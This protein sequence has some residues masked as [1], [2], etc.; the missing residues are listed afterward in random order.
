MRLGSGNEAIVFGPFTRHDLL[1]MGI[2]LPVA[3]TDHKYILKVFKDRFEKLPPIKAPRGSIIFPIE[4]LTWDGVR[5]GTYLRWKDAR[6]NKS[7]IIEVQEYGG[8]DMYDFL[9]DRYTYFTSTDFGQVWKSVIAIF[10]DVYPLIG[11]ENRL[12]LDIKTENMVWDGRRLR[13]I[14][15]HL[16]G[17]ETQVFTPSIMNMPIQF[18]HRYWNKK[19]NIDVHFKEV[20]KKYYESP[21]NPYFNLLHKLHDQVSSLQ[22]LLPLFDTQ[23]VLSTKEIQRLKFFFV[24]YPIFMTI[25]I[26]FEL[27]KIRMDS[28]VRQIYRI[29]DFCFQTIYDRGSHLMPF[30]A[31]IDKCKQLSF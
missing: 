18:L 6:P 14:D 7:Y 2:H 19:R 9:V 5:L 30:R 15:L 10:E 24:V 13:L 17:Q 11:H 28:H 29:R 1:D 12:L 26:M 16:G 3:N 25:L 23:N 31:F 4:T 22:E 20:S 8:Y 27:R 21:Q